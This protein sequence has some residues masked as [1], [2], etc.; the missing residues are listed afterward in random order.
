[1]A[2]YYVSKKRSAH[3]V[4]ESLLVHPVNAD[5]TFQA[6]TVWTR[7]QVVTALAAG[8][9]FFTITANVLNRW[10]IGAQIQIFPVKVNYLKTAQDNQAADNLD[11]LPA[12]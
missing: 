6:G 9:T 11:N 10:S 8:D 7:H 1:M 4:I 5:N 2:K 3:G 12:I